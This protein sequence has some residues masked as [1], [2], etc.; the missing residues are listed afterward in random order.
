MTDSENVKVIRLD[1][2][3]FGTN[4]YLIINKETDEAVI[5]DPGGSAEK[6]VK[7]CEAESCRPSAILLTHGHTDHILG[8]NDLKETYPGIPVF[9][10]AEDRVLLTDP[11]AYNVLGNKDYFVED[12][13][14]LGDDDDVKAGG[15]TFKVLRTPGHTAGSVCYYLP[16]E[17]LL[18]AGDT[19]FRRSYGRYDLPTGSYEDVLKSV[20]FLVGSLPED[21]VVLTGHGPATKIAEEKAYNSALL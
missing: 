15:L 4:C 1:V 19:L 6:I 8:V 3:I 21:V 11:A 10:S 2:G 13:V 14:C 7:A 20:R 17:K 16:D 18:F 12:A 9:V 5:I